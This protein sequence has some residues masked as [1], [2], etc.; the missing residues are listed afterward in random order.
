[1][2]KLF[3]QK[4]PWE[5]KQNC[6]V[7]KKECNLMQ[8]MEQIKIYWKN[9]LSNYYHIFTAIIFPVLAVK[10][11]RTMQSRNLLK[12][13][14]P[15]CSTSVLRLRHNRKRTKNVLRASRFTLICIILCVKC[16]NLRIFCIYI[17][18]SDL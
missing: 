1:M 5:N 6:A 14:I 2:A 15:V 18:N 4:S 9:N 13:S 3:W 11:Y 8:P 10:D 7:K 12:D 16:H 17:I